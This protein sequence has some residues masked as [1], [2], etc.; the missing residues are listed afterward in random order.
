VGCFGEHGIR[1]QR[2]MTDNELANK[3]LAHAALCRQLGNPHLFTQSYRPPT[4]RQV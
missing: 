3:S 2:L 4:N 1:A